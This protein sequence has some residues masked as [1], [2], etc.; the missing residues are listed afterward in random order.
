MTESNAEEYRLLA[1]RIRQH[2]LEMTHRARSSHV[3]GCFSMTD[4]LAV[5]YVKILR[6]RPDDPGWPERDRLIISKGHAA[7]AIYAV[8]AE[9]GFFPKE[10]LDTFYAAGSHLSGHVTY[11]VPGIEAS[12]GSLGHGLSI[13]CGMAFAGK[14]DGMD[15]KTFVILSDGECDEGSTWEAIMFAPHHRLDNLTAIIDYNK[16]Q[17]FGKVN[18]VLDLEPFAEKWRSFGWA[19]REID[20]HDFN[21]IEATLSGVPFEPGKPSCIIAH[22]VKGKGISFMENQLAWHYLPVSDDELRQALAELGVTD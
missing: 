16:L 22:T 17:S 5:L 2:V 4:L 3:G 14:R 11:G 6:V 10:W 8:L 20:G 13:G 9:R 15:Y 21:S 1:K 19:V 7:A 18:E 12:T